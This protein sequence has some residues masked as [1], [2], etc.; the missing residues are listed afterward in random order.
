MLV[1]ISIMMVLLMAVICEE[2]EI[3]FSCP[4]GEDCEHEDDDPL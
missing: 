4:D 1:F 2:E 3:S